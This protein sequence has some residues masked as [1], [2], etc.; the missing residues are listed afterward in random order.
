MSETSQT[1]SDNEKTKRPRG[2]RKR[3][4]HNEVERRRKDK[5]NGWI[6]KIGE[7]LPSNDLHKQSKISI[8]E[9]TVNYIKVLT[10]EREKLLSENR[11]EVQ[12][13]EVKQLQRDLKLVK[14]Q[15][16]VYEKLLQQANIS[17]N[18]LPKKALKYSNRFEKLNGVLTVKNSD[19][20]VNPRVDATQSPT[21]I[22]H[23]YEVS[24]ANSISTVP[25]KNSPIKTNVTK[26]SKTA[27]N[28]PIKAKPISPA[29]PKV[30]SSNAPVRAASNCVSNSSAAIQAVPVA[31]NTGQGT[32]ILN[33]TRQGND[34]LKGA[35]QNNT[36][37][38]G[39]HKTNAPSTVAPQSNTI[40]NVVSQCNAVLNVVSQGNAVLNVVSLG[41]AVSNVTSQENPVLNVASN[42]PAII[43]AGG[44]TT[45]LSQFPLMSTTHGSTLVDMCNKNMGT[46]IIPSGGS[47]LQHFPTVEKQSNTI[48]IICQNNLPFIVPQ[49]MF[50]VSSVT[51]NIG[52]SSTVFC[53][54]PIN[55]PCSQTDKSALSNTLF[56]I[57]PNTVVPISSNLSSNSRIILPQQATVTG[58]A[59]GSDNLSPAALSA[60]MNPVAQV[61]SEETTVP[62]KSPTDKLSEKSIQST[63]ISGSELS[64]KG[65][66]TNDVSSSSVHIDD[67]ISS[68]TVPEVKTVSKTIPE[69]RTS[70]AVVVSKASDS[71]KPK[72]PPIRSIRNIIPNSLPSLQVLSANKIISLANQSQRGKSNLSLPISTKDSSQVPSVSLL[73]NTDKSQQP[74]TNFCLEVETASLSKKMNDNSKSSIAT[75]SAPVTSSIQTSKKSNL[76][77]KSNFSLTVLMG[78]SDSKKDYD[79][80][81]LSNTSQ[82]QN[83]FPANTIISATQNITVDSTCSNVNKNLP[84]STTITSSIHNS[85][86]KNDTMLAS[87]APVNAKYSSYNP[88]LSVA[89]PKS[90]DPLK[91]LPNTS[92]CSKSTVSNDGLSVSNNS[93]LNCDN[94]NTNMNDNSKS[95]ITTTAASNTLTTVSSSLQFLN[96]SPKSNILAN[97]Q[98]SIT[99]R[100]ISYKNVSGIGNTSATIDVMNNSYVDSYG[101]LNTA[102]NQN[103]MPTLFSTNQL[104]TLNSSSFMYPMPEA[105]TNTIDLHNV[106]GT[107]DT[108][109]TSSVS[110]AI[111]STDMHFNMLN[112][113]NMVTGS[114]TVLPALNDSLKR[115]NDSEVRESAST[116][117][118]KSNDQE[119]PKSVKS[120]PSN[121]SPKQTPNS[122]KRKN[123]QKQF[124][125][126]TKEIQ[127]LC[128]SN[129]I[130]DINANYELNK[131]Q[132]HDNPDSYSKQDNSDCLRQEFNNSIFTSDI[133]AR[134]TESIFENDMLDSPHSSKEAMI[135]YADSNTHIDVPV[136]VSNRQS[137]SSYQYHCIS[138]ENLVD[139]NTIM[140]SLNNKKGL[141]ANPTYSS[142]QLIHISN[143]DQINQKQNKT[144]KGRKSKNP[145]DLEPPLKKLKDNSD[146]SIKSNINQNFENQTNEKN[147]I[148]STQLIPASEPKETS[149]ESNVPV[150][151]NS[152]M[153]SI[154]HFGNQ[155]HIPES[156]C[157]TPTSVDAIFSLTPMLGDI[158]KDVSHGMSVENRNFLCND[159]QTL[160]S[161][162]KHFLSLNFTNA[163]E[164]YLNLPRMHF[165]V[166]SEMPS[167]PLPPTTN[168]SFVHTM[169]LCSTQS[170]N[171]KTTET[172]SSTDPQNK[173]DPK[174]NSLGNAPNSPAV[175]NHNLPIS[176]INLPTSNIMTKPSEF[177]PKLN[178]SQPPFSIASKCAHSSSSALFENQS[179]SI[180]TSNTNL[181]H[182]AHSIMQQTDSRL[183]RNNFISS[184]HNITFYPPLSS[185][186]SHQSFVQNTTLPQ[187]SFHSNSSAN[188]SFPIQAVCSGTNTTYH[189]QSAA[190]K[191][192]SL[193]H[194]LCS[195]LKETSNILVDNRTGNNGS[196]SQSMS[197][198]SSNS[199]I[200]QSKYSALSLISDQTSYSEPPTSSACHSDY[201][202]SSVACT[203]TVSDAQFSTVNSCSRNQRSSLS[204]SAESLL[205]TSCAS[206]D[207]NKNKSVV[208]NRY[209][210]RAAEKKSERNVA[211][212][213]SISDTN[214]FM[215]V[216][217]CEIS[218]QNAPLVP[219]PPVTSFHNFPSTYTLCDTIPSTTIFNSV[220]RTHDIPLSLSNENFLNHM[221]LNVETQMLGNRH[222]AS[223]TVPKHH[224][225]MNLPFEN[226]GPL[227][228]NCN[229]LPHVKPTIES[230]RASES[231]PCFPPTSF[232]NNYSQA[233]QKTNC[234][235]FPHR[236][237]TTSSEH[238]V[239]MNLPVGPP[240]PQFHADKSSFQTNRPPL[241]PTFSQTNTNFVGNLFYNSARD[242]NNMNSKPSNIAPSQ[243]LFVP[244]NPRQNLHEHTPNF[245]NRKTTVSNRSKSKKGKSVN[246]N[247]GNVNMIPN[248][249]SNFPL[250]QEP[251]CNKP[252]ISCIPNGYFKNNSHS[253]IPPPPSQL[254]CSQHKISDNTNTVIPPP[255]PTFNPVLHQQSDNFFNL[256]FQPSNFT[257]SPLPRPPTQPLS[258]SCL[259]APIISHTFSSTNHPVPNF[260]LS[261][262]LPDMGCS[263]NQVPLPPVKFP[264]V[265]HGIQSSSA[266]C[267]TN[268]TISS[269]AHIISHQTCAPA[270]YPPHPP[271]VRGPLNPILSHNPQFSENQVPLVGTGGTPVLP[272]N[273]TFAPTQ[274][275]PFR[276]VIH[277]LSFPLIVI[278]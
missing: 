248:S 74:S 181:S 152:V 229:F 109:Q 4:V 41:N 58:S 140:Q 95:N 180:Q 220:S 70:E 42:N 99:Q 151:E 24:S 80:S 112:K 22:S 253:V 178:N 2:A 150:A 142:S 205:Q 47:I 182:T 57:N 209:P 123:G 183:P 94:S 27:T 9:Q 159:N 200:S 213:H 23:I 215:P 228:N 251:T 28:K 120:S 125:S 115:P 243:E 124:K 241:Q 258:C 116:Y 207:K 98:S 226:H 273:S 141:L 256:N 18:T 7:L 46:I 149:T 11:T 81:K 29:P 208:G 37:L 275:P 195:L 167:A 43:H 168:V 111:P 60:S 133:L 100:Q 147:T 219:L 249:I 34:V 82:S 143:L 227:Y 3:Q 169:S 62:S 101:M 89:S 268:S 222:E 32:V 274:N 257:M 45:A 239:E 106:S 218:I 144:F 79:E 20:N 264:P 25:S 194:S 244:E 193:S 107:S 15:N 254:P 65:N 135:Y 49:Q 155:I 237:L 77:P 163:N 162:D 236:N 84:V 97:R 210:Q 85:I 190:P 269:S 262:I 131:A 245:P 51:R 139:S 91:V 127:T 265:N 12:V 250:P 203:P 247:E 255:N 231:A 278:K 136:S 138:K 118:D 19:L 87:L 174:K 14:E 225:N 259:T 61:S 201:I 173:K 272:Q 93:S 260:N 270:L 211:N 117:P 187:A 38:N 179:P 56:V 204:Y 238:A 214:I 232:G 148:S 235:H 72:S 132:S 35:S 223:T 54:G 59:P 90:A 184:S 276:N 104:V 175:H 16:S 252:N 71:E 67:S 73:Q 105:V 66:A 86:L 122:K 31:G 191:V 13:E 267:Q 261:N 206:S 69:P 8:L 199:N 188:L 40:L 157:K 50:N 68:V 166:S 102:L 1:S 170:D 83:I 88:T 55:D 44:V 92:N 76:V 161:G 48:S 192:D 240:G 242:T 52:L 63:E 186:T 221:N 78:N 230:P 96:V 119:S 171:P 197:T 216:S 154:T 185:S 108:P 75:Q 160:F 196:S 26:N 129:E 113:D 64:N 224:T 30:S 164:D 134:A 33:V 189:S 103:V 6:S 266:Q 217:S 137:N 263:G 246:I 21:D 271:I 158:L 176:N 202:R 212:M 53:P 172:I 234:C 146:Q 36:V 156:N 126:P 233:S 121:E 114:Y 10:S 110:Y 145:S 130:D 128:E 17:L 153:D 177:L 198:P 39:A 165:S 277:S 5:I